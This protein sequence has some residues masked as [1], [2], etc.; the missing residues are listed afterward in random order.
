MTN[1]IKYTPEQL[2]EIFKTYENRDANMMEDTD[3][4]VNLYE[5]ISKLSPPDKIILYLYAELGSLRAVGRTLGVSYTTA[6]KC[7]LGIRDE[8]LKDLNGK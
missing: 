2:N 3:E 4:L 5:S 7:V 6:R 8:I 1:D